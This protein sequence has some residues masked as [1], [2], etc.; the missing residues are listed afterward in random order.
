MRDLLI[1]EPAGGGHHMH[2]VRAIAAAFA[3]RATAAVTLVTTRRALEAPAAAALAR[4]GLLSEIATIE[5][6]SAP[7]PFRL[8]PAGETK[9]LVA[10]TAALVR[11]FRATNGADCFRAVLIPYIDRAAVIPLAYWRDPFGATPF[12]GILINQR[13]HFRALGISAAPRPVGDFA[14]TLSRR[15]LVDHPRLSA[16]FTIDPY[17]ARDAGH[18]RLIHIPDPSR[19]SGSPAPGALRRQMG[20]PEDAIVVLAYGSLRRSYKALDAAIRAASDPRVARSLVLVAAGETDAAHFPEPET[21]RLRRAGRLVESGHYIDDEREHALFDA[22]DIVWVCYRDHTASSNVLIK[23]GQAGKPVIASPSGLLGRLVADAA[24]G[25][26][27]APDR[28]DEIVQAMND[29][30]GDADRR[31]RLG[32]AGRA[33]FAGNTFEAFTGPIV[34][35]FE[36]L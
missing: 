26:L 8:M 9:R 13:S 34:R 30:A 6:D 23:A 3:A 32:A 22:A 10:E 31:R 21:T 28:H 15:R 27:A 5:C 18:R 20:L 25:I 24:C 33:A 29:L 36:G 12:G 14:E 19:L 4:S 17:L 16:L 35:W 7:L 1:F 2:Y 11:Y